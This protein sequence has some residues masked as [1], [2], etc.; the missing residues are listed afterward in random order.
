[1]LKKR[2]YA[3]KSRQ[4]QGV[5]EYGILAGGVALVCLVAVAILRHKS[6][7]LMGAVAGSLP[8]AHADD[9][10]PFVSR[11]LVNTQQDT[12]G[13]VYLDPAHPGSLATNMGMPGIDALVV[14]GTDLAP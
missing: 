8:G 3:L 9:G 4:G 2:W 14:E 11:K 7:D 1:M 12:N 6:S 5:V 13:V 10:G